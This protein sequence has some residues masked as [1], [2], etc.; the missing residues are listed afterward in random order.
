MNFQPPSG[1]DTALDILKPLGLPIRNKHE[2]ELPQPA[3][4]RSISAQSAISNSSSRSL[5][6]KGTLTANFDDAPPPSAQPPR[7]Y[8]RPDFLQDKNHPDSFSRPIAYI[9]D[10]RVQQPM[11]GGSD[12]Y[13]YNSNR[14]YSSSDTP[15]YSYQPMMKPP[16][17]DR[18]L[19]SPVFNSQS[20]VVGSSDYRPVSA[21]QQYPSAFPVER[22]SLTQMLPPLPP[23]RELPFAKKPVRQEDRAL[24]I[25]SEDPSFNRSASNEGPKSKKKRAPA[26]PSATTT[27][28][29]ATSTAP[30]ARTKKQTATKPQVEEIPPSSA[31]VERRTT[32]A[33]LDEAPSS[34]APPNLNPTVEALEQTVPH[35]SRSFTPPSS[36]GSVEASKKRPL[37]A[38]DDCETNKRQ[39]KE[40][41]RESSP[42]VLPRRLPSPEPALPHQDPSPKVASKATQYSNPLLA[43]INPAEFLDSLE[44]WIQVHHDLP[45]PKAPVT[46]KDQLAEYAS[47]GEVERHKIIDN[48]ICECL[49][50][51]NFGKLCDDLEEHWKRILLL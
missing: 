7:D 30:K 49:R 9:Q 13:G 42:K 43:N 45:A 18:L 48:M 29:R 36:L 38:I 1:C 12:V 24:T 5:D 50:D 23:V 34:S 41:H 20:S 37:S 6:S 22:P 51:E 27:N 19:P 16:S 46:A 17:H 14:P 21:P 26:K 39:P 32:S 40:P 8:S 44:G 25:I 15:N 28:S 35:M 11:S 47:K 2:S 3:P 4:T 31:L 10:P 33:Y